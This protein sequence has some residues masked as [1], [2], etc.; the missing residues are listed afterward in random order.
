MAAA[1][2]TPQM[3]SVGKEV[4]HVSFPTSCFR[5]CGSITAVSRTAMEG[6]GTALKCE[7]WAGLTKEKLVLKLIDL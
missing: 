3:E 1:R 2:L 4:G 7:V 5:D 6:M